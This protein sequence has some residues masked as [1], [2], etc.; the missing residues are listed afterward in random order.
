LDRPAVTKVTPDVVCDLSAIAKGYAVDRVAGDLAAQGFA[1]HLVEIGG[2]LRAAGE[3]ATG[4]PWR[5]AVE[6]PSPTPSDARAAHE[7]VV[8]RDLGMAT[9]G[10]YRSFYDQGGA[11]ISH[12]IDPRSGRPIAH[13]LASVTVLHPQAMYADAYATALNVLGP[14]EGLALAENLGLAAYFI[15][16]AEDGTFEV[17]E[18]AG[19]A[20]ARAAARD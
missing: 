12:T 14:E 10:D 5:V 15:I 20:S 3:R 11:R 19:F 16:R 1:N 7:I 2:E 13:A 9:S 6:V 8:L 17:L 18:T 4:G